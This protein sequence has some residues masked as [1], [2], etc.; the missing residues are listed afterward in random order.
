MEKKRVLVTCADHYMGPAIEKLFSDEG[1]TV[2]TSEDLLLDQASVDDL[3]SSAGELDVLVANL[4]EPPHLRAVDEIKDEEWFVL[5]DKLVHPLMRLVRGIT[6]AFKKQGHGKI[7]AV[8]SAAPLVGISR[9]AGYCA[10]RGAQ[11]AFIRSTGLEL[12]RS[13]I[14][15]NAIAQNYVSND[16]YYADE[17]V[18]SEKFQEHLK[19][20]V[21]RREVAEALETAELALYLSLDSTRHMVGQVI[22]FA[23][24]WA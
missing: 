8:T 3:L 24:G 6:P 13:N 4:S 9:T 21:P 5:F 14:Q 17:M 19:K 12:A 7:I 10:A 23:G 1:A 15:V 20:F 11:N 16:T 18:A 2:Q 22:P